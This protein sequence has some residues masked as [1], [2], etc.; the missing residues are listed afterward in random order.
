MYLKLHH[1]FRVTLVDS[2]YG[3]YI[4][5]VKSLFLWI[6]I[7]CYDLSPLQLYQWLTSLL[8][9]RNGLLSVMMSQSC[10]NALPC[11]G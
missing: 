6:H 5:V 3:V 7:Y 11:V 8:Y 2:I 9:L 10:N 4:E 1:V